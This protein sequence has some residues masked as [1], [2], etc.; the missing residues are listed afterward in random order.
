M[1]RLEGQSLTEFLLDTEWRP[2]IPL[3]HMTPVDP[4]KEGENYSSTT[5]RGPVTD[6]TDT[7]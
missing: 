3:L 1:I 7:L 5:R 6:L 4:F 2:V